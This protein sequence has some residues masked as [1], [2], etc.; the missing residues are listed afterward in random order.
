MSWTQIA[1]AVLA[2]LWA[3]LILGVSFVATPAK[4]LAPSLTLPVALDVG[5][6]TFRAG[7]W[8]ELAFA[9][10]VLTA[11]AFAFGRSGKTLAAAV[12]FFLLA[13]QRVVLLPSLDARTKLVMTGTQPPPSWHHIAWIGMDASRFLLLVALCVAALRDAGT[14]PPPL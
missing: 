2:G 8:I 11:G 13:M 6:A 12:A 5:R 3:G 7:L 9:A 10:A 1:F 4:F 14:L